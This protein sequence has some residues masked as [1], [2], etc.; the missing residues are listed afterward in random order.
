M[1]PGTV[2]TVPSLN[3]SREWWEEEGVLAP[4]STPGIMMVVMDCSWEQNSACPPPAAAGA[5][6]HCHDIRPMVPHQRV[7]IRGILL[8]TL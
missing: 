3:C 8:K 4:P 6:V 7:T 5:L 1:K 2:S